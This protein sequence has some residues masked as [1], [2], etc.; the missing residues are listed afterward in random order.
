MEPW[1]QTFLDETR[2]FTEVLERHGA[3]DIAAARKALTWDL[4][5]AFYKHLNRELTDGEAARELNVSLDTLR[6]YK[7]DGRFG[8][9]EDKLPNKLSLRVVRKLPPALDVQYAVQ[10]LTAET[11]LHITAKAVDLGAVRRARGKRRA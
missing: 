2:A 10:E 7:N 6:R 11:P 5:Q 9:D 1:L 4:Q 3:M 8:V